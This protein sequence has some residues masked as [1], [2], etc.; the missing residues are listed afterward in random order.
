MASNIGGVTQA[1]S[2]TGAAAGQVLS[3]AQSLSREAVDLN[4]V[5]ERFL[6]DVRK[7]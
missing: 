6:G 5:V 1:A 3:S 2:E 7:A 4:G